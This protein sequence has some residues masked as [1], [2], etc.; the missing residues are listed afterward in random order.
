MC[1]WASERREG[2]SEIEIAFNGTEFSERAQGSSSPM[3]FYIMP[4][5]K[6]KTTLVQNVHCSC[7][8]YNKCTLL[9]ILPSIDGHTNIEFLYGTLLL[10]KVP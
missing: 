5:F 4:T 6:I 8:I 1:E 2:E 3:L 9:E 10:L 7:S